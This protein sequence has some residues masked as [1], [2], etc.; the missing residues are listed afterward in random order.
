MMYI[1]LSL[2]LQIRKLWLKKLSSLTRLTQQVSGRADSTLWLQTSK[3]HSCNYYT[4]QPLVP[5]G[6]RRFTIRGRL[7]QALVP[8]HVLLHRSS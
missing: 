7:A 3:G 8:P 1:Q 2:I 5:G 6:Q 4:S